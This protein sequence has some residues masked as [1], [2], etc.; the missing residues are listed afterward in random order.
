M[1]AMVLIGYALV[2]GL[3]LVIRPADRVVQPPLLKGAIVITILVCIQLIFGAVAAAFN[4]AI[5][6]PNIN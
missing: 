4:P 5:K 2:F 1:A 6:A 3:K